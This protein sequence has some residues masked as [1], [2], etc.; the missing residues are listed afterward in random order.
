MIDQLG[1]FLKATDK[2]A[3]EWFGTYGGSLEALGFALTVTP[4]PISTKV[5]IGLMLANAAA[6]SG[7]EYDPDKGKPDDSGAKYGIRGCCGLSAPGA[8]IT[9]EGPGT[10]TFPIDTNAQSIKLYDIDYNPAT[11]TLFWKELLPDGR[12]TAGSF[13]WNVD[14]KPLFIKYNALSEGVECTETCPRGEDP[15]DP[16]EPPPVDYTNEEGCSMTVN[17]LGFAEGV[18]GDVYSITQVEPVAI[19]PGGTRANGGVIGGC[20]FNPSIVVNKIGGG[21]GGADEPPIV[22]PVP[23]PT[24]PPGD[25]WWKPYVTAA[26]GG[27]V[28]G[29]VSSLVQSLLDRA[30]PG[31]IYRAV[32]VCE[33]DES[34]ESISEVVEVPIPTLKAPDAQLARL[35]A[36]VELLQAHKN[37]K[38]PICGNER[39]IL[40]G[41]WRTISFRS[42][43]TSPYGKSRLC[44][45]FRYRSLSGIGLGSLVDHWKDFEWE[46]G[47]VVVSHKGHTWGTPQ[48]W[49]ATADE[50][51]RVIQ[52]AAREAGF[53]AD[54]VGKWGISSSS[55]SRYGVSGQMK[56]DT[57]GGYY[58][59][60]E[61]DGSNQRP[62]VAF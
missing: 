29:A 34:G 43:K 30:Y 16:P 7:C 35:D 61:R 20:F 24:P 10:A 33:K 55:G 40:E 52:H 17:F 11:E 22:I 41:A 46:S 39:P 44:K 19:A 31:L 9:A 26:I 50:G 51:K 5:G 47:P 56:V 15:D 58:W 32:S 21:G 14:E 53:D 6:E 57:T 23:D 13:K 28:A 62:I 37:F 2:A 12:E 27:A 54:Q 36:I 4:E 42:E 3:C 8:W 49:A 59:V 48:V 45:R 60:T 38:Q 25:E 1:S 18:G